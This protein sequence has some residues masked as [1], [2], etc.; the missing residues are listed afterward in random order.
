MKKKICFLVGNLNLAGGTERA[1]TL[2]ANALAD[3]HEITILNLHDG[4]YPF[5]ELDQRVSNHHLFE[6]KVSMKT[7]ALKTILGIRAF[8]KKHQIDTLIVVD[9]ISCVFS[10]P[11]VYGLGIQHIC[12]EHFNFDVDLGVKIRRIGRWLATRY[13]DDIVTLT[14][15]D[16]ELWK[17]RFSSMHAKIHVI[18]NPIPFLPSDDVPSLSNKTVLSIGRLREEKGF[19]LLI[20]AWKKVSEAY[21]DWTLRIVGSGEQEEKLK[22]STKQ[23][24]LVDKIQFIPKTTQLI[25]IYQQAS[26]YCLSSKFESFGMVLTEALAM[27]LPIVAFNCKV[28]PQEI[29]KNSDNLLV[30]AENIDALSQGLK[31]FMQLSEDQYERIAKTNKIHAQQYHIDHVV[32]GLWNRLIQG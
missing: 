21:P 16:A 9:S 7:H 5:F 31:T 28:G 30:E 1:T 25:P 19:D 22:L 11:A 3:L 4:E 26:L 29:L 24:H 12:W 23:L 10:V 17:Q 27:G 18:A 14:H 13:C 2:V 20:Q 15:T 6:K 8:V 32:H